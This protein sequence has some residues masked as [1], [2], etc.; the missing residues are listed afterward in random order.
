MISIIIIHVIGN[1]LNT[2]HLNGTA[3]TIYHIIEQLCYFAIPLFVMLSGIFFLNKDID[4][5]KIITKYS[6]KILLIILV[7][8]SFYSF[9][10]L[11]FIDKKISLNLFI[12][13]F[14]N[15]ITGN[16][17]A[18]MWYLYMILGLY[19]I[20]PFLRVFIKH[21][22]EKTIQYFL[23]LMYLF[24]ILIP[25]IS[26][27]CNTK[28]AFAIPIASAYTFYYLYSG[29][30]AKKKITE[31]TLKISVGLGILSIFLVIVSGVMDTTII[32]ITYVSTP[33]FLIANMIFLL[34][35]DKEITLTPSFETL[36]SSLGV[37]SLG[38]YILHQFYINI[39]Y[40]ILK[41]KLILTIPYT[42]FILYTLFILIITYITVYL[43]K[44]IPWVKDN[45]L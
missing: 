36:I 7:F 19:L 6:K 3:K 18:H 1:T 29:Y 39:I 35:K 16:L 23:V 15:L 45:L 24:S 22:E 21:A 14:K 13:I 33:I 31:R 34:F 38:I 42:G 44:K 40:K 25:E 2:Y 30:L 11:F 10:E 9:L 43:L 5:R 28:I 41:L 20:T 32:P 17:W 26:Y 12:T 27:L 4:I 37:C 8:G